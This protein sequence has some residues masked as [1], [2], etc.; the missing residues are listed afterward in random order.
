ML[1]NRTQVVPSSI[2]VDAEG[3]SDVKLWSRGRTS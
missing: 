2:V 1:P 3:P